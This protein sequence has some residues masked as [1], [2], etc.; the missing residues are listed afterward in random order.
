MQWVCHHTN[1]A[2][3]NFRE[4]INLSFKNYIR[5]LEN[6]KTKYSCELKSEFKIKHNTPKKCSMGLK[7]ESSSGYFINTNSVRL[8]PSKITWSYGNCTFNVKWCK[9]SLSNAICLLRIVFGFNE[10]KAAS[11]PCGHEL[12]F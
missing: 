11:G 7:V 9:V 2:P 12:E 4:T 6:V 10:S 1:L 3:K 5:R 8:L